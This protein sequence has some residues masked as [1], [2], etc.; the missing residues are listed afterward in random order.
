MNFP[1]EAEDKSQFSAQHRQI[2]VIQMSHQ[3][4]QSHYEMV[5]KEPDSTNLDS[6][7]VF[8]KRVKEESLYQDGKKGREFGAKSEAP[9]RDKFFK[10]EST[11]M[12]G[13]IHGES[14]YHLPD[15]LK[16]EMEAEANEEQ[17]EEE[18]KRES[19]EGSEASMSH[20]S[21]GSNT[22]AIQEDIQKINRR[23]QMLKQGTQDADTNLNNSGEMSQRMQAQF[24][25]NERQ[26][27]TSA[28]TRKEKRT[29]IQSAKVRQEAK[30]GAK[31]AFVENVDQV[32]DFQNDES[33][34]EI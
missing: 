13:L 16:K 30:R 25:P 18:E 15:D 8:G 9:Q 10:R 34:E 24:D 4:A 19:Y 26:G 32:S 31:Q 14:C 1:E 22:H 21:L 23:R 33:Y 2:T 27:A 7:T 3:D 17:E 20:K 11:N 5:N 29:R 12:L 28:M 6:K